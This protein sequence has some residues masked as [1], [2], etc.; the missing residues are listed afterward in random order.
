ETGG[1]GLGIG[2]TRLNLKVLQHQKMSEDAFTRHLQILSNNYK[3]SLS[4][5]EI[6]EE[7][8]ENFGFWDKVRLNQRQ[9]ERLKAAYNETF[10]T[11]K[12]VEKQELYYKVDKLSDLAV[13]ILN[14]IAQISWSSGS[15]S[16]V[17]VPIFAI[18]TGAE[19]FTGRMDNIDIPEKIATVA[20]YK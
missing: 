12:V 4:W 13:N 11:G 17:Y 10:G 14:E 5:E 6:Q 1:F 3:R 7:L 18:G 8:K 19:N 15:H 16:G 2:E 9:T 20:G